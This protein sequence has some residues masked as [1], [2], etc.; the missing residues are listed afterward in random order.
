MEVCVATQ[1]GPFLE[2]LGAQLEA[3]G[4]SLRTHRD[5]ATLAGAIEAKPPD[6]LV[7][8]LDL[9]EGSPWE[10]LQSVRSGSRGSRLP[11]VAVSGRHTGSPSVITALRMGAVEYVAKPCDP[12][13]LVARLQ[14]II[15][16][17]ERRRQAKLPGPTLRSSGGALV[18]DTRAHR[19]LLRKGMDQED[20]DLTPKEFALL[21]YLLA[22]ADCLVSKEELARVLWPWPSRRSLD[23]QTHGLLAQHLAHLRSK[24][25]PMKEHLRTVWG[26]GYCW[27]D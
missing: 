8:D 1:D 13:V 7:L 3:K 16:A 6:A 22:H 17:L 27:D 5:G 15:R 14:A 19:C 10:V 26:L 9:A 21:A 4:L 24:L 11:V 23:A 2:A 20:L 25:G 12:R 18:L